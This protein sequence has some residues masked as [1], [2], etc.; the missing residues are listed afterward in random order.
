ML[1]YSLL[2]SLDRLDRLLDDRL[3]GI[4]PEPDVLHQTDECHQL[5]C[6]LVSVDA[7]GQSWDG[8][9]CHVTLLTGLRV[10]E[11]VWT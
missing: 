1:E 10:N 7:Q 4:H 3:H 2:D 8:E 5:S 9:D 11:I 6:A